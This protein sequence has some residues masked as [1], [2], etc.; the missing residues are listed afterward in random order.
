MTLEE[1]GGLFNDDV[2]IK[3]ENA[4]Q[5]VD[6]KEIHLHDDEKYTT[7]AHHIERL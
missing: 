7:M 2:A 4:D 3:I 6:L 1:I 5:I